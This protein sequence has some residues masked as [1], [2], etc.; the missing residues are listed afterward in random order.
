MDTLKVLRPK[1]YEILV[2]QL[3]QI[4]VF[5]VIHNMEFR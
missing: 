4:A 2:S 1:A 5:T 3:S